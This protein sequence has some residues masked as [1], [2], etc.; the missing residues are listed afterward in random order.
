M[1]EGLGYLGVCRVYS[2]QWVHRVQRVCRVYR[3]FGV[4]GFGF[5]VSGFGFRVSGFGF[6]VMCV[7]VCGLGFTVFIGCT[8]CRV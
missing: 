1:C 5:R 4:S 7:C 2:G 3:V 8:G 6:R